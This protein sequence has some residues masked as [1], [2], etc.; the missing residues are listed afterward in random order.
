[1]VHSL[2]RLFKLCIRQNIA[3]YCII[4]CIHV[5][6]YNYQMLL[7]VYSELDSLGSS[8]DFPEWYSISIL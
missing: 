3:P 6:T 5:I 1:M 2:T 7:C 4:K 8:F